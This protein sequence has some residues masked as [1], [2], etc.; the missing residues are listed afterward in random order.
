VSGPNDETAEPPAVVGN[1]PEA[2]P[3]TP[4]GGEPRDDDSAGPEQPAP[5]EPPADPGAAE[6]PAPAAPSE[7]ERP[8][9]VPPETVPPVVAPPEEEP[10][11]LEEPE[12][13]A[14]D[15][16][17]PGDGEPG[18]ED[19][20][21]NE[22]PDVPAEEPGAVDGEPPAGEEPPSGNVD[23][24]PVASGSV[25][26]GSAEIPAGL[27]DFH[28]TVIG[29]STANG[30]GAS[31]SD[32][33]WVT[34]LDDTLSK[35]VKTGYSTS[36]LAVGG[37][38][39]AELL[40]G[41]G[42][43]GSIDDAIAEKPDLIVVALAGSNDIEPGFTT[44]MFMTQMA[45]VREAARAAGI[46]TFFMSPLPKSLSVGEREILDEWSGLMASEFAQCW[47]PGTTKTYAPCYIDVFDALADPSLGLATQYDSGDGQHPNDLG[48]ALLFEA[49][50]AIVAPY[51]CTKTECL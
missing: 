40:P 21:E 23:P 20:S 50:D 44:E 11:V 1:E 47:I 49:V 32:F 10:P 18:T 35:K 14:E 7:P 17:P 9:E 6:A 37:Y 41:S 3:T 12:A 39:A 27:S 25:G 2:A 26:P 36:N 48:H 31:T 28:I 42:A 46:P 34:L 19:P 29:S 24:P 22:P 38:K 51:V 30:I 8:V 13:P 45:V 33:S 43:P 16:E 15:P 5:A 4:V